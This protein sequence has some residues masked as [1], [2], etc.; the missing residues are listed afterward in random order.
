M[1]VVLLLVHFVVSVGAYFPTEPD[2]YVKVFRFIRLY[3]RPQSINVEWVFQN[4]FST[5][6]YLNRSL[7]LG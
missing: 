7:P 1:H 2:A 6:P 4:A 3:L 5:Y